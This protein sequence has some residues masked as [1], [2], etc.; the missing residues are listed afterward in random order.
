VE[1]HIPRVKLQNHVKEH[2]NESSGSKLAKTYSCSVCQK[3]FM[4][5]YNLKLHMHVHNG[6]QRFNCDICDARF[7]READLSRHVY[8]H[9][10]EYPYKCGMCL[11]AFRQP[12]ELGRHMSWHRGDLTCKFCG[13]RYAKKDELGR[14]VLK[15]EE[16]SGIYSDNALQCYKCKKSIRVK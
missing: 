7:S 5:V 2:E 6:T 1:S 9:T 13:K 16:V 15:H 12:G 8:R 3:L 4:T 11:R 14:H 10:G